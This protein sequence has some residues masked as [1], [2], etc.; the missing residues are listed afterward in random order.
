[1][2][3][4]SVKMKCGICGD[5]CEAYGNNPAP[6]VDSGRCC[7]ECDVRFVTPV[8]IIGDHLNARDLQ[9]VLA[10]ARLGAQ[11]VRLLRLEEDC[12]GRG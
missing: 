11:G 7:R 4:E 10:V 6:L 5:E 2:L 3:V 9:L 1:M 12:R 8:R